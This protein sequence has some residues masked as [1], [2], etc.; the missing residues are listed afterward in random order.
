[1]PIQDSWGFSPDKIADLE[2]ELCY[3]ESSS[4]ETP[5][6]AQQGGTL[7]AAEAVELSLWKRK[8]IHLLLSTGHVLTE[9]EEGQHQ[10]KGLSPCTD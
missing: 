6:P 7:S 4:L 1:M 5:H 3:L 10:L 9:G 8:Q 2:E